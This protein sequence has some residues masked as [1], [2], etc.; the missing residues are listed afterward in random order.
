MYA[1]CAVRSLGAP[2]AK[3]VVFDSAN[4]E[5]FFIA[6]FDV[7]RGNGLPGPGPTSLHA[8]RPCLDQRTRRTGP[9]RNRAGPRQPGRFVVLRQL[10]HKS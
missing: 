5:Y 2:A 8:S 3:V 6:H 7:T 9:G 1:S 4:E 10:S